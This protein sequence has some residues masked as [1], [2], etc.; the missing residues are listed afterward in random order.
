VADG[1][2]QLRR[3]RDLMD[4]DYL[5]SILTGERNK[6]GGRVRVGAGRNVNSRKRWWSYG[7]LCIMGKDPGVWHIKRITHLCIWHIFFLEDLMNLQR[8]TLNLSGIIRLV[9]I[10]LRFKLR[11]QILE[12][13]RNLT[14]VNFAWRKLYIHVI[15]AA[16]FCYKS[17]S[18][19]VHALYAAHNT[20]RQ[21]Q[22]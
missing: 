12:F 17:P 9:W 21:N 19:L 4:E 8:G 13:R 1:Q 6:T 22:W 15:S 7:E 10:Q 20:I 2:R 16:A 5:P 18:S 14:C 3:E 11:D